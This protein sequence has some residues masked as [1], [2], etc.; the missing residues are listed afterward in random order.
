MNSKYP[1]SEIQKVISALQSLVSAF[2]A[3]PEADQ[4]AFCAPLIHA[5]IA[6][7]DIKQWEFVSIEE[8]DSKI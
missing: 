7:K 6:L 2:D 3:K 4:E 5:R 1:E 8:I